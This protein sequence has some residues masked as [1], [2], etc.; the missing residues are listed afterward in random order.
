MSTRPFAI[1]GLINARA[2][3]GLDVS[4]IEL[5]DVQAGRDPAQSAGL[6]AFAPN[7][8]VRSAL[9]LFA[10]AT[11]QPAN[12]RLLEEEVSDHDRYD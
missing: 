9:R 1:R 7:K 8:L 4:G 2:A 3:E 11:E 6:G 5:I 12:E 10:S